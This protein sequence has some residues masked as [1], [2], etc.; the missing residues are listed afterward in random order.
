MGFTY[1]RFSENRKRMYLV[2]GRS[3][4]KWRTTCLMLKVLFP[5]LMTAAV[6]FAVL[7]V[8][9]ESGMHAAAP[10]PGADLVFGPGEKLTYYISW[11]NI[12]QAGKAV[13]EVRTE[14]SSDGNDR[15]RIVSTAISAGIVGKFYKVSDTVESLVDR[16]GFRTLAFHLDQNHG[17]R[18]KKRDMAFDRAKGIVQVSAEGRQEQYAVPDDVQDALSSLYYVRTRQDFVVGKPIVVNVH[19]DGK[20]WAVE[21]ITLGRE[22]L[23]TVLGE[24]DTIKIKTYPRYEGVFQN[25]GEIYI[26]LT[27]DARKIPVLMKSTITIGT[28]VSTLVEVRTGEKGK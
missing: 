24:V 21:V 7:P 18:S 27:D 13:L 2:R 12:M 17:K 11:S 1:Y 19:D 3:N 22:K 28:I 10:V 15:Y 26:W 6:L 8:P 14:R 16:T 20:T 25:K 9:A 5:V 4:K 23:K